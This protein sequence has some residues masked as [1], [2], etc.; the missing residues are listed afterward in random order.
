[1][2]CTLVSFLSKAVLS[3]GIRSKGMCTNTAAASFGRCQ[4]CRLARH[5]LHHTVLV[6]S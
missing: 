2:A 3:L 5:L 4:L 1:M 6:V